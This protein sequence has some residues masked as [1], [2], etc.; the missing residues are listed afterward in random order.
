[1]AQKGLLN[2]VREKVQDRGA[3]PKEEGDAIGEYKVT[4]EE[5]IMCSGL[6]EDGKDK[7]ERIMEIDKE[8]KEETSKKRMREEEK[9]ENETVSADIEELRRMVGLTLLSMSQSTVWRKPRPWER[10][11]DNTEETLLSLTLVRLHEMT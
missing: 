1:M 10:A 5:K 8:T 6:R 9:K 4:H 7:E 11:G 2:L 3:L